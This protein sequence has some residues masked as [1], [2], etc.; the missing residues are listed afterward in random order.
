MRRVLIV[1]VLI[2][3]AAVLGLWRTHGGVRQGLNRAMGTSSDQVQGDSREEIRKSFPIQP[4]AH[5]EIRGINGSVEIQT[6]D[7]KTAEVYVLRTGN[8]RESL[9][10]RT[11]VMEQVSNGLAI[12]GQERHVGLWQHLF[13]SNPNEQVTIK[14][15]RQ[16][17]LAFSGVNG[18]VSGSDIEGTLEVRSVNGKVEFG[19]AGSSVQISGINGGVSVALKKLGEMGARISGVNGNID[20]RLSKDLN[21]DLTAR[22]MNGTVRSE[23]PDLNI[24]KGENDSRYEARI[25][26]GGAP[27][28]ISGINGNVRL[29]RAESAAVTPDDQKS[30]AGNKKEAKSL[31]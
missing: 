11:V 12:R 18:A 28:S 13:G 24:Q 20:L 31:N 9:E 16:I 2:V 30:T 19:Q 15:P 3:A 10:R 22:G 1:V 26:T 6:S 7:T 29:I 17:A 21:A 25:G 5:I 14:A 23:I 27:I 4:G 8:S